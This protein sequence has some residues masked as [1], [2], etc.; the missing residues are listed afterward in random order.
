MIDEI[1]GNFQKFWLRIR[2]TWRLINDDR[3][4]FWTKAIPV[5]AFLYLFSPLDILPD[6][7]IVLG[8]IDDFVI[9]V[10]GMEVFER[11]APADV[12]AEHRHFL[13]S[14]NAL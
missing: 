11:L 12:V 4:P 3:V 14:E 10:A 2:L 8:Q 13:E 6:I 9:L 7:F 1:I 5:A